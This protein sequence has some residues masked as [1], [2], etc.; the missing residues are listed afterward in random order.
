MSSHISA[1][2]ITLFIVLAYSLNLNLKSPAKVV[3]VVPKDLYDVIAEVKPNFITDKDSLQGKE[4]HHEISNLEF[5][6]KNL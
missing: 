2:T 4:I 5:E 6:C 1:I 3:Y